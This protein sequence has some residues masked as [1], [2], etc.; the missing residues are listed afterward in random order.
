MLVQ[1]SAKNYRLMPSSDY[2]IIFSYQP[3]VQPIRN[4][5][6]VDVDDPGPYPGIISKCN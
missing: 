2:L 5:T 3:P 4:D 1:Q 6:A